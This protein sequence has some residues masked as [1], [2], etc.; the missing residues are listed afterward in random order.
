MPERAAKALIAGVFFLGVVAHAFAKPASLVSL[1]V[2]PSS[3]SVAAGLTQQ[4]SATG[5]YSDGT[6]KNI[7]TSVAWTSSNSSVASISSSGLATGVTAGL[8]VIIT[9]TSGALSGTATLQVSSKV[10]SSISVTP[11]PAS[12]SVGHSQQFQATGKYS[13]GSTSVL[14]S[15]VVWSSSATNV[16]TINATG[17]AQAIASGTT[18][19]SASLGSVR[20]NATL[21]VSNP[22]LLSISVLP[23]NPTASLG[24]TVQFKATGTYSDNSTQDITTAVT[25]KSSNTRV[26]TINS[27]GVATTITTGSVTITASA[28]G[29][30]SGNTTLTVT[31]TTLVSMAIAPP[32]S[33]I[34]LG[35]T[36]QL[37][38]IGTYSD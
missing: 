36:Q 3:A 6:S 13:D 37:S 17:L 8:S 12:L 35:T 10:L 23:S 28:T 38:A 18:T 34:P 27:S 29:G 1:T 26:A 9:A 2:S 4:F 24:R 16:A 21:T 22:K 15:G 32:N 14:N 33:T 5:K 31:G 25:W 7:T 20:G 19:I 11:S 30:I